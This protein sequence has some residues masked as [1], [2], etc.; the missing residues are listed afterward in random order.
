LLSMSDLLKT[1]FVVLKV[2]LD[3]MWD[4][5]RGILFV[6][7]GQWIRRTCWYSRISPQLQYL[8]G[9]HQ[10]RRKLEIVVKIWSRL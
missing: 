6:N 1:F 5:P 8:D 7:W 2:V 3:P 10:F 4:F 9:F